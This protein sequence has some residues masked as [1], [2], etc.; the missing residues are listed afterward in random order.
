MNKRLIVI[1]IAYGIAAGIAKF[2]GICTA[3]YS[4]DGDDHH[5]LRGG[6]YY[7]AVY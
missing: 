7:C 5:L 3:C 4:G 1:K 2:H 6:I